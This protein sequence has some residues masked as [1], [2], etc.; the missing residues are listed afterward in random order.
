MRLGR[1]LAEHHKVYDFIVVGSG[2]G[3]IVARR[4]AEKKGVKV[5]L[6]EAGDSNKK[7]PILHIPLLSVATIVPFSKKY[8]RRYESEEE[9][10]LDDRKIFQPRGKVLG[11]SSM[12]NGMIWVRGHP[13]DYDSWGDITGDKSWKYEHLLQYFNSKSQEVY[14]QNTQWVNKLLLFGMFF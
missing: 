5:L 6:L 7:N 14:F 10:F 9:T 13:N 8:N 3:S 12:I 1:A 11:G 4:L 2:C